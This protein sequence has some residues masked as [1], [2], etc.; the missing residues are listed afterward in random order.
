MCSSGALG[1]PWQTDSLTAT[2]QSLETVHIHLEFRFLYLYYTAGNGADM[3]EGLNF[4]FY[5]IVICM[6]T[7]S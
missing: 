3:T 2:L 6:T 5:F 1:Y 4:K 7:Y